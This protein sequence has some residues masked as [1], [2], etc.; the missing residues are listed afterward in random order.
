MAG[1]S[2]GARRVWTALG[3]AALLALLAAQL[4]ASVRGSSQTFDEA[5]HVSA[6]YRAWTQRDFGL[7]PEPPPLVKLLA[8]APLLG[9]RWQTPALPGGHF[10]LEAYVAGR[11]FLY[12]NDADRI[13]WR[14]RLAVASLTL[15]L[16]LLVFAAARSLFGTGPAFLALGLLVFEPNLLAHGAL[17]TTDAGLACFLFAAVWAFQRHLARPSPWNLA[18]VG[19]AGGCTLASKHAGLLLLPLLALLA[20]AEVWPGPRRARVSR[21]VDSLAIAGLIALAVL[22]SAYGLRQRARPEGLALAPPIAELL[23]DVESGVR[24][25]AIDAAGRLRLLPEAYLY[26]LAEVQAISERSPSYL[27]GR[28]YGS[29]R[30]F[31]F[32]AVFA[33]KSTL[34]FLALLVL[35]AVLL[36]RGRLGG[37]RERLFLALPPAFWLAAATTSGLNVGVRHLLPMLPFL[38]VLIG[39]GA[40]RFAQRGRR[41]AALVAGLLALHALSSVA[42]HPVYLAYANE[43][44][45]GPARVH[46]HLT[47]SNVDWGQQLPA[48]GRWLQ[49][50]GIRECWFAYFLGDLV[51]L[52]R[53]GVPCRPLPSIS[54]LL[55]EPEMEVPASVSG[56]VLVSA[57]VLSGYEF[58]PAEMNPYAAFQRLRPLAQIEHGVFVYEGRFEIPLAAGL[59]HAAQARRLLRRGER[60]RALAEARRAAALAPQA[61]LVH[62][63]LADVFAALGWRAEARGAREHAL[64]LARSVHPDYQAAWI[65]ALERALSEP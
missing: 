59:N 24:A 32:P 44:F 45:G 7:N 2:A 23:R 51:D 62:V 64:A 65:P 52:R 13:L 12:A 47:D 40:F 22:W 48:V 56:T 26:G 27:F 25:G 58:G 61:V 41:Q 53:Y 43:L 60:E 36:A 1:S 39:A 19:L 38:A 18:A 11:E 29:G 46:R 57:S 54:T 8:A 9:E 10:K 21:L 20:A 42:A 17:V 4:A 37:R 63:T 28:V 14:A 55:L 35:S 5:N 3:V 15:A 34:G 50:Q 49:Q 33:I 6:G 30:W 16:A 31:Y